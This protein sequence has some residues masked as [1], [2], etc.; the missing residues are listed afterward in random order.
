MNDG[1]PLIDRAV[2][3]EPEAL[4]RLVASQ[5]RAAF[6]VARAVLGEPDAAED[7]AQDT[8]VRL[9]A[10]LPGFTGDTELD[11]WVYRV[12]LNLCRDHLRRRKRRARDIPIDRAEAVPELM[13]E[14]LPERAVDLER[15]GAAVAEAMAALSSEQREILR[16]RFVAGLP[17]A[18]IA[19]VTSTPQGTIASRVFRALKRLGQIL[20]PRHLE[21][22][23]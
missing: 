12:T 14:S 8:V 7:I 18:D 22:L 21:V 17:Y 13:T 15:A 5:R 20:D 4:E 1:S 11:R 6:R 16:L 10:A 23:E 19:R 3:G 2:R 9:T